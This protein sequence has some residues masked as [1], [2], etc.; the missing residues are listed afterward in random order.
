[1]IKALSTICVTLILVLPGSAQ[2]TISPTTKKE[3]LISKASPTVYVTFERAGP[4]KG[5]YAEESEQGIWLRVHNNT[6]WAIN[7]HTQSLYLGEKTEL[8]RLG[9]GRSIFGL[10]EGVE[11]SPCHGVEIVD[12]YESRKMPDGSVHINENVDVSDPPVGYCKGA[13]ISASAWLASGRSVIFSIPKEHLAKRLAIF[14]SF[15][16]EWETTEKDDGSREPKHRVYFR[17]A[18]LPANIAEK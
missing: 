6:K 2:T 10:R 3:V 13:H 8:I 5:V 4:R 17:A 15:N 12:R 1:M 11:I 16:Y 18:D 9:D 7:I 14:V